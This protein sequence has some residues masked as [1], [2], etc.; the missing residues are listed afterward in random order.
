MSLNYL[1]CTYI[2]MPPRGQTHFII[3]A[4]LTDPGSVKLTDRVLGRTTFYLYAVIHLNMTQGRRGRLCPFSAV[5]PRRCPDSESGPE[6]V[7][8]YSIMARNLTRSWWKD[9]ALVRADLW[10]FM[11]TSIWCSCHCS[12]SAICELN[13]CKSH[14]PGHFHGQ[15]K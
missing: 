9:F 15:E 3:P 6:S 4:I 2:M 11:Q 8:V 13:V 7:S 10:H 1:L 14:F 5:R 12:G